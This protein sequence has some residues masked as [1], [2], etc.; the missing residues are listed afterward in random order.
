MA[1]VSEPAPKRAKLDAP[2]EEEDEPPHPWESEPDKYVNGQTVLSLRFIGSAGEAAACTSLADAD[3]ATITSY[4]PEFV[5][6]VFDPEGAIACP[7]ADRPQLKL[8]VNYSAST[9]DWCH[10]MQGGAPAQAALEQLGFVMPP[11]VESAS[12]LVPPSSF[13]PAGDVAGDLQSSYTLEGDDAAAYEVYTAPLGAEAPA[14]RLRF[15]HGLQSYF[16]FCI[17]TSEEIDH[18]DDR[19]SLLTVFER[20]AGAAD[21][22]P[23]R[24]VG[25]CSLFMFQR[26]VAGA[27]PLKLMRLCQIAVL[28]PHRGKR[29]GARLLE[30]VYEHARRIGAAEVTIEQPNDACCKLR[31]AVDFAASKGGPLGEGAL[32]TALTAD[33]LKA[34]K[35]A[36]LITDEQCARVHEMRQYAVARGAGGAEAD[37]D[38]EPMKPWRLLVKRRLAKQHKEELDATIS[39]QKDALAKASAD[40]YNKKNAGDGAA[41]SGGAASSSK[42]DLAA[43]RKA[44]LEELYQDVVKEYGAVLARA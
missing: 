8:A 33:A 41:G 35:A 4:T 23:P 21:A 1:G 39:I 19:W 7:V 38:G 40:E 25:A 22:A 16:R 31:D 10:A 24:L 42:E 26:W 27:G 32:G 20:P 2:P 44:R 13:A 15:A 30:A 34:A 28:P 11:P 5:H 29:H 36:L 18:A 43:A 12:E 9:L 3:A 17:E 6:Q 37:P 14:A